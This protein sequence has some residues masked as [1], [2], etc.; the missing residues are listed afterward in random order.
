MAR[1]AYRMKL[2][3]NTLLFIFSSKSFNDA[4]RRWNYLKQYDSYRQKQAR[5]IEGTQV[6]LS[7]KAVQLVERKERKE[8][9][10]L[11]ELSQKNIL[12]KELTDSDILLAR[13]R[14]SEV[15]LEEELIEKKNVQRKL[16]KSIVQTR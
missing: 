14:S 10:L 13:L 16:N 8:Q 5:L 3:D 1:K 4:F 6:T 12:D 9:L 2:T 7:R 15:R 11:S